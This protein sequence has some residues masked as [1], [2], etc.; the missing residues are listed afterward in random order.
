MSYLFPL[1]FIS[2]FAGIVVLL[3]LGSIRKI[4]GIRKPVTAAFVLILALF[5]YILPS[6]AR[7]VL[8]AWSPGSVL[9]G[10]LIVDLQPDIWWL[11]FI[12][13]LTLSG[14]MWTETADRSEKQPLTGVLLILFLMVTWLSLA[15]GSLLL[16]LL[17]WGISDVIWCV[18]SLMSGADGERIV[19]GTA[20]L[21]VSSL[22]IWAI[23][24]FLIRA[25]VS[26]LWWLVQPS[27][28][29]LFLLLLATVIRVGFYP[30][31][32]ALNDGSGED[33]ALNTIYT[34]GPLAGLGLL[35]RIMRLPGIE[36]P[37]WLVLWSVGSAAW[38]AI[39]AC[40]VQDR[41]ALYW[42]SYAGL[43]L[44]IGAAVLSA[45][46]RLLS[47]G[48]A[49][50]LG[51][52]ALL[53]IH[54]TT[55]Y[56]WS[57]PALFA[58]VLLLASP[59]SLMLT[60]YN[61]LLVSLPDP[62]SILTLLTFVFTFF[63]LMMALRNEHKTVKYPFSPQKISYLIG[64][65]L[66]FLSILLTLSSYRVVMPILLNL[67]V[68]LGL[69]GASVLLFIYG[70][71]FRRAWGRLTHVITVLDGQWLYHAIWQGSVNLL[72]VFRVFSNVIEGRGSL[73]WSLLILMLVILVVN[74]R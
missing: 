58:S 45:D 5:W 13:A 10:W 68:W 57:W 21:G 65:F 73:L 24:L 4:S 16:T 7:F 43:H 12:L 62:V 71:I 40:I 60:V 26:S 59:S 30:F 34:L 74:N 55:S 36:L 14:R 35:F 19:I 20:N 63:A 9:N 44:I 41:S 32:I 22:L 29:I 54:K 52:T 8:S 72:N 15:S 61:W 1:L 38:L 64:I 18:A 11:G 53:A 48:A 66:P 27:D 33:N 47:Y 31:H 42:V 70:E 39:R 25:G 3:G 6:S 23:S 51:I 17:S 2:G 50:W 56:L 67:F 69:L 37:H 46:T 28:S 49:F